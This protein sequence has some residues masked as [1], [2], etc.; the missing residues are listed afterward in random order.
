MI[1]VWATWHC[2]LGD[3]LDRLTLQIYQHGPRTSN[4]TLQTYIGPTVL[5]CNFNDFDAEALLKEA[6]E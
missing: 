5:F 6:G 3:T 2:V 1:V 4:V